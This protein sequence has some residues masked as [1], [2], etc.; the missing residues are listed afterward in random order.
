MTLDLGDK[1]IEEGNEG[2]QRTSG[3]L[4]IWLQYSDWR[5]LADGTEFL[6]SNSLSAGNASEL[7]RLVGTKLLDVAVQEPE[8]G[9]DLMFSE[10][11]RLEVRSCL[12]EYE[13]EDDLV[14]FYEAGR[15]PMGLNVDDGI[16]YES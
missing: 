2:S 16:Y 7:E 11:Y 9:V 4:H 8:A 10:R 12:Q 14:V 1:V 15:P 6:S 5:L 3:S 13:A